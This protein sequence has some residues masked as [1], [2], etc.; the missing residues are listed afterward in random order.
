MKFKIGIGVIIRKSGKILIGKRIGSH[1]PDT[2]SFPGGHIDN[3]ETP[4]IAAKREVLEETGLRVDDLAPLG[5]TFD[6]FNE[7]NADYLTL[8][9]YCN[10]TGGTPQVME[11][12]KCLEWRW[13]P[14]DKLPEPLFTPIESL[15]K[16]KIWRQTVLE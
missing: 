11:T 2:W 1:G 16:Q 15:V 14:I 12:N 9:Y 8:F 5:F 4:E 7:L 13:F 3:N 10:W 6:H